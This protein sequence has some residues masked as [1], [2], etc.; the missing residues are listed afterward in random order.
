[1]YVK[2]EKY[3]FPFTL[4]K[5]YG[6]EIMAQSINA[7]RK[8]AGES[9]S[10]ISFTTHYFF[11]LQSRECDYKC[12]FEGGGQNLKF[13]QV[14]II[15]ENKVCVRTDFIF[16]RKEESNLDLKNCIKKT[17]KYN[18]QTHPN[19]I[20]RNYSQFFTETMTN[21]FNVSSD[22]MLEIHKGYLGITKYFEKRAN[23]EIIDEETI[24]MEFI[25]IET[26]DCFCMEF[27]FVSDFIIIQCGSRLLNFG[28]HDFKNN[29]IFSLKQSMSFSEN[30]HF[31][32]KCI[33]KIKVELLNSYK[34]L[35][36]GVLYDNQNRK[37]CVL[38]Q[39]VLFRKR[40]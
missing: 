23:L 24:L 7:A 29:V 17:D 33:L 10:L 25:N 13:L 21:I 6:G 4:E 28:L 15:Q 36:R 38:E 9:L 19:L 26:I 39:I 37:I 12:L 8:E 34:A 40:K 5:I 22:R 27:A 30:V 32:G 1:M 3:V 16:A 31:K 2:N 11:A 18:N 14:E 20:S 35:I